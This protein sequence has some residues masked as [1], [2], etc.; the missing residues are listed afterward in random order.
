MRDKQMQKMEGRW[1]LQYSGCPMWKKG[2]IDTIS[3]DYELMHKGEDLVLKEQVEYR[4]NGKMKMKKGFEVPVD[5][6]T[7]FRWQ[8]AG[9]NKLF[10]NSSKVLYNDDG[11]LIIWFEKTV[12]IPESIDVLTKK[13]HLTAQ[14]SGYIFQLLETI[15]N[16]RRFIPQ[17]ESVNIL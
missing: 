2:S 6:G 15:E 17:L 7:S 13:K 4:K 12:S 1:Y 16:A 3:F 5:E 10:R 8:G 11:I 14:E 9:M